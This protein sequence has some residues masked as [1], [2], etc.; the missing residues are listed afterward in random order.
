MTSPEF[1]RGKKVFLTGHTGFKGSWLALWFDLLECNTRGFAL[2]PLPSQRFFPAI[3]ENIN[4]DSIEGD[5]TNYDF[6]KE[7]IHSFQ[8]EIVI[9][10]AAQPLVRYSYE[11]P[12]E[13]INS[14]VL[15]TSHLMEAVTKC[16]SVRSVVVITTDKCY[17]NNE[18]IWA[19]RENE[20][21]GG[22]DIYSASKAACEL[23]THAF[24]ESFLKTKKNCGVATARAGN[25]IGGG[26]WAEDRIVT[27]LV[28]SNVNKKDLTLRNPKAT[29]PWQHVFDAL[30]G[31]L[32]LAE[33]AYVDPEGYSGAWNFGPSSDD[34]VD[35]LTLVELFN[36]K[37]GSDL[38]VNI[39][40]ES[41][42]A[43]A[44]LL[45]LDSSKARTSLNWKPKLSLENAVQETVDWYRN[46]YS[47]KIDI[48]EY[49][50]ASLTRYSNQREKQ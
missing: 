13:T 22:K 42:K 25:I 5:V 38:T 50:R 29:R 23:I 19:Y 39:N 6:L 48:L 2:P 37:W 36:E 17:Q 30:Y 49:S 18:W 40:E 45:K 14:N 44:K 10:L 34:E 20:S 31:Y 12:L 4:I 27:D 3:K 8:P 32:L 33:K 15:G 11:N 24:Y 21:L 28:L 41:Q 43:E 47:K 9:H 1:W 35:V 16:A 46:W 7:S 26:D